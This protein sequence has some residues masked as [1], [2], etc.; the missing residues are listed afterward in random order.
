VSDRLSSPRGGACDLNAVD[1]ALACY[2]HHG[3]G[4][5]P[6]EDWQTFYVDFDALRLLKGFSGSER[7]LEKAALFDVVFNFENPNG[8]AFELLVD[9]LAF[10]PCAEP[11]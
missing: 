5:A 11:R 4:F 1:P 9:D 3:K 6:S 2:D 7:P 8:A 10:V